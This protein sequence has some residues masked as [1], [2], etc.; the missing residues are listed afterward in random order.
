MSSAASL[1]PPAPGNGAGGHD[2]RK[3]PPVSDMARMIGLSIP[4]ASLP[5]VVTNAVL[6]QGYADMLA[7][8]VLPDTCEPAYEYTP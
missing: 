7:G 2:D 6:L 8:F 4:A 1:S 5:D 3:G